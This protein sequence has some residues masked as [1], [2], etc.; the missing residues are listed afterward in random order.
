MKALKFL[1]ILL[2]LFFSGCIS[3][4]DES[5]PDASVFSQVYTVPNN[6]T[7]TLLDVYQAVH[8]HNPSASNNLSSCF[9]YAISSFFDP[10]YNNDGYAP[11]NSMKRFRNYGPKNLSEYTNG[12]SGSWTV[13]AGITTIVVTLHGGGGAGGG[14]FSSGVYKGGGGGG[15]GAY[16]RV[17]FNVTSGG[18][19]AVRSATIAYGGLG[20]GGNG[21]YSQFT[22]TSGDYVIANGGARGRSYANGSAGGSGGTVS[23]SGVFSTLRGYSGG[24]GAAGTSTYSG[25]GGGGA[26]DRETGGNAST[27]TGGVYKAIE[28]GQGGDGTANSS[29]NGVNGGSFG[30]GGGGG[31]HD[32][33]G[34]TGYPGFVRIYW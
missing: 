12:S 10:T 5:V 7:F 2:L 20:D 11:A 17:Q 24:N 25:G 23:T 15:G 22:T 32:G 16:A 19:C 14:G 9:T 33:S 34:G 29:Q 6:E 31:T 30:G 21:D 18:S 4:L 28:G 26:S 3:L 27:T 8:W 13:P 1:S